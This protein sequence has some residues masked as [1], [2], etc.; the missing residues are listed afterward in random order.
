MIEVEL[1]GPLGNQKFTSNA[2]DFYAL[3][4]ELQQD[5]AIQN[6]LKDCAI[7]LND[8][9]VQSLDTPLKDGDKVVILP[10]VCGG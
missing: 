8:E 2:K 5:S 3:K 1:L 4:K 9:I 7:A 10:P 6:W